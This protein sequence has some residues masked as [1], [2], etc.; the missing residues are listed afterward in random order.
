MYI[1]VFT[2]IAVRILD[3]NINVLA[4]G[5]VEVKNLGKIL[6]CRFILPLECTIKTTTQEK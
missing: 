2:N 6:C 5:L 1:L 3:P 4:G